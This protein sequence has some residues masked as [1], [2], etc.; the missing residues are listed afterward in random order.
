M[1]IKS[2]QPEKPDEN[3]ER[4]NYLNFEALESAVNLQYRGDYDKHFVLKP[5]IYRYHRGSS[6]IVI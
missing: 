1:M 2:I 3:E 4:V 6:R 5:Y